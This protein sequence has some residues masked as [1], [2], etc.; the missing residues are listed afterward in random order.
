MH[1]P[2]KVGE[3]YEVDAEC[4]EGLCATQ[5]SVPPFMRRIGQ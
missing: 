4:R 3:A 2:P 1:V 5:E